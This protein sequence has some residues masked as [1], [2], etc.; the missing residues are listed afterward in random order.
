VEN[1]ESEFV[2]HCPC[3]SCGSSDANSLYSNGST[4]CFNCEKWC[5]PSDDGEYKRPQQSKKLV[6]M[7]LIDYDSQ[8]LKSRAIPKSSTEKYSYGI[9][10]LGK[11]ICQVATYYDKEK[12]PVA[13][14]IRF[15]DKTFKFLGDTKEALMYGQHLFSSGGKKLTITEGEIDALSVSSAFDNKYPVVSIATGA[16]SARKEI[17]K[18]LEWISSFDEIYIWFDNDEPGRKATEQVCNILPIEKVRIIRHPDYKDANELLVSKGK[19]SIINAFYNAEPYK[20]EGICVPLDIME[21]ALKP[22]EVGSGWFFEKLTNITYGRRL[23][24]VVALG[25]GVS[26]GKT[27]VVMQSIAYDLKQNYNVGTFM[28]EQSTRETLLRVAGKIDGCFYHLP[29]Q[30]TDPKKL[31]AT[32]RSIN[33]LFIYDNFGMIDWETISSKIRFMKHSFGVQYFYID[34]LTALNAAADDERRNLDK[35]MAE[36]AGLAQELNIWILVVSH[37]NPPK[38]GNSHE[39]GGKVEQNQ[40]T[41]SR[42]IM[43]WSSLMLGVERNTIAEDIEERQKGLIRVIKDRFSG[44]ATGQ[45][46]G[47]RYDTDTGTLLESDEIDQLDGLQDEEEDF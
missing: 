27:D 2:E 34:N 7:S 1:N 42:S 14:K 3:D 26:V 18:H 44:E 37:L 36:V 31:E 43:R 25:A 32:I 11:D 24:E 40:F 8:A 30:E 41:G 9:G 12:Q 47:F 23:G 15:K 21:E 39:A 20:P 13:Q 35:L 4:Y 17:A 19:P 5:P 33:G 29:N 28:L 16:Q 6:V 38:K 22:V 10:K 46:I 45:T